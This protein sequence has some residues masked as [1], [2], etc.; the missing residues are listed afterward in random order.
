[1]SSELD[2]DIDNYSMNDFKNFFNLNDSDT[3][4]NIK[5][6][7]DETTNRLLFTEG[8]KYTN[9]DK[10]ALLQFINQAKDIIISRYENSTNTSILTLKNS[11]QTNMVIGAPHFVQATDSYPEK[12]VNPAEFNY[13]TKL[14]VFN[15]IYSDRGLTNE[16]N[17]TYNF[18]FHETIQNVVGINLAALQY[19]NVELAFS[20][21]KNNN[22]MY[23]QENYTNTTDLNGN[24]TTNNIDG[25]D[26]T[27]QIPDGT[28]SNADFQTI[29]QA[30]IN[31]ALGYPETGTDGPATSIF[32]LPR[33][34]VYINPNSYRTSI[35]NNLNPILT[36]YPQA[37]TYSKS[38]VGN[39]D[40]DANF[41]MVF[42][43]PTWTT[44]A[45]NVCPGG[46]NDTNLTYITQNYSQNS[47]QY[48]SLGYQMGFREIIYQGSSAYKST[49]IYNSNIVN[50]VYFVLDDFIG[51]RID[52][53]N[54]LFN[55]SVFDKNI[56][57][58]V[59]ITSPP[60][61]SQLDSGAN[62]IFKTRNYSGPVKLQK[63]SVAF[64]DPNGSISNLDGTPFSFALELKIAYENPAIKDPAIKGLQVGFS[65]EAI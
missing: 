38:L 20:S 5:M 59:P 8:S 3:T 2:L 14:I 29:L 51:N 7:I 52:N 30:H 12:H 33:Y 16:N 26:A 40:F 6:K 54:G 64:Y 50:Y 35:I 36:N 57:A 43:K 58:L 41:T 44:N 47:L 55:N 39:I 24:P 11:Q 27:I 1:M 37:L 46:S 10:K 65:E 61:T 22:L 18:T 62:F 9:T 23:I 53:V 13:R 15:S 49:S 45:A 42:D 31:A 4:I 60:F 48:R 34:Y 28:Y 32:S 21:Y 19:P 25:K 63:I 56:L 17:N